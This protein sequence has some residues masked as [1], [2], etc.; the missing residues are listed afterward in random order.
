MEKEQK[1]LLADKIGGLGQAHIEVLADMAQSFAESLDIDDTLRT[2]LRKTMQYLDA[3]AGSVFLLVDNDEILEC[4][5]SEGPVDITGLRLPAGQGI[6]GQTVQEN[7]TLI[8][9]DVSKSKSFNVAV[10]ED[11]GFQ[12]RSILCAPLTVRGER[13][14]ALEL[15]NKQGS[16]GLFSD[17]DRSFLSALASS[18]ALAMLNARMAADLVEQEKVRKELEMAR[19]IQNSLLPPMPP[20]DAPIHGLNIPARGVSG[21]LY[22]FFPLSNGRLFFALGDVSG[23]GIHAALFMAKTVSLIR[24]LAKLEHSPGK[25]F[26]RLNDEIRETASRGMFITLAA[27]TFDPASGKVCMTNA[28]H[29]PPLFRNID[30]EY[31]AYPADAPPLGILPDLV[32]E[33]VEI[34]LEGGALYLFTDGMTEGFDSEGQALGVAGVKA[35]IEQ[36]QNLNPQARIQAMVEPLTDTDTQLR[37]DITLLVV[38]HQPIQ[39]LAKIEVSALPTNLKG[40]RD[41]LREVLVEN[42]IDKALVEKLVLAV[43]EAVMNVVQH[44]FDEGGAEGRITLEV[45][46]ERDGLLF[47]LMDNAPSMDPAEVTP[48]DLDDIRPGGLG[49]HFIREL[50]DSVEFMPPPAGSGNLLE[51]RKRIELL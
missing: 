4:R 1:E 30:G 14:G 25:L 33:E 5:A 31:V 40:L 26:A 2:A 23:K 29:E 10:D 45:C 35:A 34:M 42:E 3:E 41:G 37:D 38:E 32:F 6:V 46:K 44:G 7:D 22:L 51:M 9:R 24:A 19:E 20:Q 50:M 28:G 43:G 49:T 21:D 11:T 15:I 17:R 47:R 16:D 8:I 27:G 13:L 12:T 39:V 18:A 48:R 36:H